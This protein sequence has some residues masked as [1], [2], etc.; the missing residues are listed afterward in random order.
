MWGFIFDKKTNPLIE[1]ADKK[2]GDG[3]LREQSTTP[4]TNRACRKRDP[5]TVYTA[6]QGYHIFNKIAIG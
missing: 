6:R 5:A 1:R 3:G 2:Q 4:T